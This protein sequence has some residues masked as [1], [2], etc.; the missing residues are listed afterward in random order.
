MPNIQ[1]ETRK[2]RNLNQIGQEALLFFDQN[3]T[4]V[5]NRLTDLRGASQKIST[6]DSEAKED[7]HEQ[8]KSP[9]ARSKNMVRICRA[10]NLQ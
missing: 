7:L 8:K 6:K 10:I 1:E 4:L 3:S 9:P 5:E 2:G